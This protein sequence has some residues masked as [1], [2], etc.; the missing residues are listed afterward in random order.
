M[1]LP[2]GRSCLAAAGKASDGLEIQSGEEPPPS[3]KDREQPDWGREPG[4]RTLV[5]GS[6]LPL[7]RVPSGHCS[8]LWRA[9]GA[10]LQP[11][12]LRPS[13]LPP[14]ESLGGEPIHISMLIA[15]MLA[16]G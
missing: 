7:G 14:R 12:A 3:P 15:S 4:T 1:G 11:A 8:L 6:M 5:T 13:A 16:T 10:A 9:S 2:G